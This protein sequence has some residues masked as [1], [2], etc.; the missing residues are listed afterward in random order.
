MEIKRQSTR[1]KSD[2]CL[3]YLRSSQLTE[4]LDLLFPSPKGE[5]GED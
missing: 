1:E 4:C 3:I 2:K 5:A